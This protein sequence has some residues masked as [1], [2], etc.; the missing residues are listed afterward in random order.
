MRELFRAAVGISVVL[1]VGLSAVAD[2]QPLASPVHA[3]A[4]SAPPVR[5]GEPVLPQELDGRRAIRG[6]SVDERC[7]RPGDLLREFEVEAFPPP[8]ASPWLDERAPPPSRLEPGA[9]RPLVR[10]PSQ[11]R[12]D[13]PWL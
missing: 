12:S 5:A 8:G 10:R 11:L 1:W 13:A 9:P 4:Q 3:G 7:A 6:C 2:A